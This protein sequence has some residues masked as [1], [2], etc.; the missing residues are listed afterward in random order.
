MRNRLPTIIKGKEFKNEMERF[1]PMDVQDRTLRKDKFY[2]FLINEVDDQL[3]EVRQ[4]LAACQ[5]A[6]EF[7][8]WQH[9][10]SIGAQPTA[11]F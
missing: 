8:M 2:D 5:V 7:S 4:Q 9:S 1:I 6:D 11:S 3:K 10:F